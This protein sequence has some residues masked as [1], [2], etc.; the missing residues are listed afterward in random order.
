MLRSH[1]KR[2][3]DRGVDFSFIHKLCEPLYY[4]YNGRPAI[5]P[6]LLFRMFFIGYL[7]G[8]KSERRLE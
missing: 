1:E 2:R 5:D 4:P 3:L 7:H 8:V 6:E